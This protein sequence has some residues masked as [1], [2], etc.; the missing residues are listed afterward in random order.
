MRAC[1]RETDQVAR[2][3]GD[4]FVIVMEGFDEPGGAQA[5]AAKIIASMRTPMLIE[6]TLRTVSTSVGV[7]ISAAYDGLDAVLREARRP[8]PLSCASLR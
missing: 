6:G 7:A 2:L 8:N 1:V 5:V 3:G 4:E